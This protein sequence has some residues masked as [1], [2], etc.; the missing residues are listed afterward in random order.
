MENSTPLKGVLPK[1]LS[2]AAL[3]SPPG[4]SSE[5]TK[6][7]GL[8]SL[9]GVSPLSSSAQHNPKWNSATSWHQTVQLGNIK[10]KKKKKEHE[11]ISET[12]FHQSRFT[13]AG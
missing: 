9:P 4:S 13:A 11:T 6:S 10:K 1:A 3:D 8:P 2:S 7:L 5:S 12:R